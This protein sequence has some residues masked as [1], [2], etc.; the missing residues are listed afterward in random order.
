MIELCRPNQRD[1]WDDYVFRSAEA[2]HC[3]L[4]GWRHVIET[5]YGH[6]TLPLWAHEN[7]KTKGI[8]PLVLFRHVLFGRSLV[9]MP[10][11]DDGGVCA[12][13]HATAVEL[14]RGA[15]RLAERFNVDWLDLR[16]RRPSG[17]DLPAYGSKI[18]FALELDPDPDRMWSQLDA[19]VRNQIRKAMKFGLTASWAGAEGLDPFYEILAANMRDL[20]SPVHSRRFFASILDE[21]SDSARLILV[22]D[23][24]RP[25]GAG[26]CLAFKN[27]VQVP[28]ASSRREDLAKCPNNLLYW[29]AIR[30]SCKDGF[31]RFD[32]GRSSP[33]SG[34]YNFK[35]Q[36]KPAEQPLAWQGVSRSGAAAGGSALHAGDDRYGW[37]SNAWKR[38]PVPVTKVIGPSL[39]KHISS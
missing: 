6:R 17:L 13:D 21:F 23:G 18:T 4:N 33:G 32:F 36:W 1:A 22:W 11:L 27:T 3:H 26:L 28:W 14:S 38:L 12:D 29:E 10:F 34:T 37:I 5:S 8:L 2:G 39:R 20:G 24:A 30:Q 19:K 15:L 9:S 25:I 35:K 31:R 16:H 7:G